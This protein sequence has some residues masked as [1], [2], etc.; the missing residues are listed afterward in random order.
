V[1][2]GF[3]T[4]K[5]ISGEKNKTTFHPMFTVNGVFNA[6]YGHVFLPELGVVFHRKKND[7][8]K[9]KTIFILFDVGY[10]VLPS[11][12]LRYGVGTFMTRIGGDGGTIEMPNGLGTSSFAMPDESV[13][14]YNFTFDFGFEHAFDRNYVFKFEGYLFGILK[15]ESRKLSYS[16]S[17]N[18]IF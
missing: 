4:Q 9:K 8:I 15:E 5:D 7:E 1:P 10:Q 14:S 13:T 16:V 11:I 2:F 12:V 6:M 18:Y 17:L 3:S